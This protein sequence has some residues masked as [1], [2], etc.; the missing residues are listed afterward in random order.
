MKNS[1]NFNQ[2]DKVIVALLVILILL[3]FR[4]P[5]S[6]AK[7]SDQVTSSMSGKYQFYHIGAQNEMNFVIFNT[8]TGEFEKSLGLDYYKGE[9]KQY[10]R[11]FSK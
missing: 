2:L 4:S 5:S 6:G 8:E 10:N 9:L 7:E 3:A 11:A 1:F